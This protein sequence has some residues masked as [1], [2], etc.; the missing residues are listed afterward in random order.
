MA[1]SLPPGNPPEAEKENAK[2]QTPNAICRLPPARTPPFNPPITDPAH[3]QPPLSACR[4]CAAEVSSD[5]IICPHCGAPRPAQADWQGEGYEWQTAATWLGLPL[6][7]VAFGNDAAGRARVARGIVAIGLRAVGG[8]AC[9][10]VA[11]GFVSIGIVSVGMFSLGVVSVAAL[12]A[13]G[14]NALGPVAFGVVACGLGGGGVQF[15]GWK[16]LLSS[17]PPP[18]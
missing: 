8:L 13:V 14:V 18:P 6:I 15:I 9:G 11:G 12:L 1:F 10:I 7:H 5:A 3:S 4:D 16:V 17:A 2:L